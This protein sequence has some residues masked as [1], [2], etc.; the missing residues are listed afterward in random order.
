MGMFNINK[1]FISY[2]PA[3]YTK[4]KRLISKYLE[5]NNLCSLCGYPRGKHSI[6][7]Y[8]PTKMSMNEPPEFIKLNKLIELL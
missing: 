2:N 7:G 5:F 4:N 3:I 8:C 1:K 6:D